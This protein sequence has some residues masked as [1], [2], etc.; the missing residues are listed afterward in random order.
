MGGDLAFIILEDIPVMYKTLIASALLASASAAPELKIAPGKKIAGQYIVRLQKSE[1]VAD[2]KEHISHLQ[3]ELGPDME[4]LNM[5]T[6]LTNGLGY[7]TKLTA[8]GLER[9]LKEDVVQFI[10]EDQVVDLNDCVQEQNPDWGLARVNHHNYSATTTYTY[11]YTTGH[12]GANVDAYIIDTGIYCENNEFVNKKTGTCTFGATFVRNDET[13]GNGH[14][15]HCAGTV[16]GITYGVAK[17]ANLIAVKVLSDAGSGSTSG[18]ISGIDWVAEQSQTTGR[19]S[20]ANLSLGGGFSQTQNDAIEA[21]VAAGVSVAV[22]AGNDNSDAC[23]YSPASAPS[24][25]TVAATDKTNS[26]ASYSNYGD[27]C[28]IFGPGSSITSVSCSLFALFHH[29]MWDILHMLRNS[30]H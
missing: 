16:G 29:F 11:D 18:V 13:D 5:W 24:A 30:L 3:G 22:A 19:R 8:R 15:T 17:E 28:D 7:S 23:N 12:S 25:I 20:V 14:G 1:S 10:E 26:R 2:M 9:M 27:C 4:V 6:Q 21:L